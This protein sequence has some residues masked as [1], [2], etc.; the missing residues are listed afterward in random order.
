MSLTRTRRP[1]TNDERAILEARTARAWSAVR[2]HE[3]GADVVVLAVLGLGVALAAQ[4]LFNGFPRAM[5]SVFGASLLVIAVLGARRQGEA[6]ARR[7]AELDLRHR[8]RAAEVEE[9]TFSS[10]A[11]TTASDPSGEGYAYWIF[12][13][14]DD[15]HLAFSDEQWVPG[16]APPDAWCRDTIVV[17]DGEHAVVTLR[18]DG[19]SIPATLHH[20]RAPDFAVTGES[21]F[22]AP[23]AAGPPPW[24]VAEPRWQRMPD[25]DAT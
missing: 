1:P 16:E 2:A 21:R 8:A 18:T 22:W 13:L 9:V 3:R 20:L 19:G 25:D 15:T 24:V 17:L 10:R 6:S 7:R 11:V 23:E 14:T 12:T 5:L 4:A